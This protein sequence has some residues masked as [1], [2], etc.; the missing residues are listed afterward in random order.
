M[1]SKDVSNHRRGKLFL[2]FKESVIISVTSSNVEEHWNRKNKDIRFGICMYI[3]QKTKYFRLCEQLIAK[4]FL[5]M[6]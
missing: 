1:T 4:A 5:F 6:L 3:V 2:G